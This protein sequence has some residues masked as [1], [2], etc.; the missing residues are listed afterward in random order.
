MCLIDKEDGPEKVAAPA[1]DLA[2]FFPFK[3][4]SPSSKALRVFEKVLQQQALL[5]QRQVGVIGSK[6]VGGRMLFGKS[7]QAGP[8]LLDGQLFDGEKLGIFAVEGE[9]QD[10]QGCQQAE[11]DFQSRSPQAGQFLSPEFLS[12]GGKPEQKHHQ[13]D[14]GHK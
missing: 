11:S 12:P 3:T 8:V 7:K 14:P 4:Q 1:K 6:E 2:F 9:V 13:K 5:G 10:Q